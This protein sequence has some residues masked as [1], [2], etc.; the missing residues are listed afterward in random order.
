M[1]SVAAANGFGIAYSNQAF[2]YWLILHF[3]DHQGGA[4]ARA[5]YGNKLNRYINPLGASYEADGSKRKLVVIF[6]NCWKP[7]TRRRVS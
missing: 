2:E 7:R 4:M 5:D 6:L 3:E 1:P